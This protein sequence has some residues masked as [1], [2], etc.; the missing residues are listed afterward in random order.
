[1]RHQHQQPTRVAILGANTLFDR[2]L[3]RLLK[4]AGYDTRL[5]EASPAGFRNEL[6]SSEDVLLLSSPLT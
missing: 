4:D 5:L 6:L 2:I 1:L 3:A